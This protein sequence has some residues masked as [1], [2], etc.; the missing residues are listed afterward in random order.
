MPAT[1]EEKTTIHALEVQIARIDTLVKVIGGAVVF[2]SMS[3]G[4]AAYQA[5]RIVNSV[6]SMKESIAELRSD[7]KARDAQVAE[8]L[9]RIEKALALNPTPRPKA[10]P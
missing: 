3:F 9:A 8:S 6:D 2:A 1:P 5:G 7:F 4:Y 10:D